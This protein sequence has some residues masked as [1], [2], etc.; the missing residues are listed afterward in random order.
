MNSKSLLAA[1]FAA[2]ILLGYGP[3]ASAETEKRAEPAGSEEGQESKGS[4]ESWFS[5]EASPD[6]DTAAEK[7]AEKE[8]VEDLDPV[9]PGETRPSPGQAGREI[10]PESR[11]AG[12][13]CLVSTIEAVLD[14]DG[15][16]RGSELAIDAQGGVVSLTG[17][18]A[19]Q[20]AI[21]QV[22]NRIAKV[23]G[24]TRVDTSGLTASGTKSSKDKE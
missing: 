6:E 1:I 8:V 7:R 19:D 14:V 10:D 13:R 24:V 21:E 3:V 11:S 4:T 9:D 16:A 22:R 23:K 20:A 5:G 17:A 12:D 15:A 2:C 18:L